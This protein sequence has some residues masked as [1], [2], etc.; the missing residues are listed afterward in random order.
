MTHNYRYGLAVVRTGRLYGVTASIYIERYRYT[1][2]VG[3]SLADR[4]GL[5]KAPR[6][7][8]IWN[9]SFQTKTIS[10]FFSCL[11]FFLILSLSLSKVDA[12]VHLIIQRQVR[13]IQTDIHMTFM[14]MSAFTLKS[15]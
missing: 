5:K 1:C 14:D 12:S 9:K 8:T 13:F 7:A 10:V 15:K 2:F 4:A 3:I 11:F 6:W